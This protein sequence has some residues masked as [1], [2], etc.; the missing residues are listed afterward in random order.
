[1]GALRAGGPVDVVQLVAVLSVY[2]VGAA[3]H[4]VGR[5]LP[6][7]HLEVLRAQVD[8]LELV[9]CRLLDDADALD[10][11]HL[12]VDVRHAPLLAALVAGEEG[13]REPRSLLRA[14]AE[15]ALEHA[16]GISLVHVVDNAC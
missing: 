2:G 15:L 9:Q 4:R 14:V 11:V 3:V 1:M 8:L 16:V 13:L 6:C 7:V 12:Q 5:V 10:L